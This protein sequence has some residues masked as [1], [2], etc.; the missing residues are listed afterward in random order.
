M[1]TGRLTNSPLEDEMRTAHFH[2]AGIYK[3]CL[4]EVDIDAEFT[5]SRRRIVQADAG[6]QPPRSRRPYVPA[7]C[8]G[9]TA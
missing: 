3:P 4:I 5:E 8:S 9:P 6:P 7:A 1:V 2:G